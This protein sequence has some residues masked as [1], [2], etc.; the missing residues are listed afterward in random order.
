MALTPPR[1]P[2]IPT[3]APDIDTRRLEGRRQGP[4]TPVGGAQTFGQRSIGIILS[5]T[6]SDGAYGIRAIKAEGGI[7]IAQSPDSS[8]YDGMPLSAINTG[9]VDLVVSIENLAS[10]L[11][12]VIKSLDIDIESSLNER[13]LQQIYRLIFEEYGVDFS[14]YKKTTIVRRVERRRVRHRTTPSARRRSDRRPTRA[15]HAR[16]P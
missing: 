13:L 1:P 14:Q 16:T 6:G 15:T 12:R 5:G 3:L 4:G 2:L 11:E 8:K 7:T 9:K 10:E